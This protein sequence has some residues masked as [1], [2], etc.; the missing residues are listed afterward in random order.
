MNKNLSCN[1]K[2]GGGGI[3]PGLFSKAINVKFAY[4]MQKQFIW[5]CTGRHTTSLLR[6]GLH[7]VFSL[8]VPLFTARLHI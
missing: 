1:L 8:V 5:L 6:R 2:M 4:R 3:L 7:E